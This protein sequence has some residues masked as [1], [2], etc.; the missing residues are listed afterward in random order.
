MK[1]TNSFTLCRAT[2]LRVLAEGDD[3]TSDG[4]GGCARARGLAE[5]S[6]ASKV[7]PRPGRAGGGRDRVDEPAHPTDPHLYK[8]DRRVALFL[9]Y[10]SLIETGPH[11]I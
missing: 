11:D 8:T 7:R 5:A 6:G 10:T 1:S 9:P 2:P 3:V 4:V